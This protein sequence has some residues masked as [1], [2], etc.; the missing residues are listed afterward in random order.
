MS[1]SQAAYT[2]VVQKGNLAFW[3]MTLLSIYWFPLGSRRV[4]LAGGAIAIAAAV[5]LDYVLAGD[6]WGLPLAAAASAMI[7]ITFCYSG[8]FLH[9]VAGITANPG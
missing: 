8:A 3:A 2:G 4:R 9:L 6:W 5:G 7:A 1:W